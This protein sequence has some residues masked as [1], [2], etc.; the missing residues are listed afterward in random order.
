L[1][2]RLKNLLSG[3]VQQGFLGKRPGVDSFTQFYEA[4]GLTRDML[5]KLVER[6]DVSDKL[7]IEIR[8]SFRDEIVN[9]NEGVIYG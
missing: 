6:I 4:R 9:V 7:N 3:Q 8:F 5:E 1:T 2:E